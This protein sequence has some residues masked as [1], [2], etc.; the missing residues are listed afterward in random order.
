[1]RATRRRLDL[2]ALSCLG[3]VVVGLAIWRVAFVLAGPDLDTDA[4]G[5]H[6]IARRLAHHPGDLSAHWV[7]LPLFH[8]AQ[9][10][11]VRFGATLDSVRLFDALVT[12]ATPFALYA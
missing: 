3:V 8:Y 11:A 1:M 10:V 9:A 12:A 2:A 5:H 4:Y 6:S 7:W